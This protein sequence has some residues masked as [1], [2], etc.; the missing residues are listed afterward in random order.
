KS[1]PARE[2]RQRVKPAP[3]IILRPY[4]RPGRRTP[5]IIMMV[6][7]VVACFAYGYGF[8]VFA[9]Y[10]MVPF[11]FPILILGAIA[12]WALP[13]LG[14]APRR[15]LMT[16]FFIFF[17]SLPLW[18]N[19]LAIAL[20]GLPWITLIRLTGFPLTFILLLSVSI[21]QSFRSELAAQLRATPW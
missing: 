8:S 12:I 16:M 20:P 6:L 21:S 2:P 18:P 15:A 9:P 7:L 19:Y 13:E 1:R 17:F 14:T 5:F 3:E 4:A 10:R 11:A